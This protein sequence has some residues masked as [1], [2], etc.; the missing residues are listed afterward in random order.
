MTAFAVVEQHEREQR[1][2]LRFTGILRGFFYEPKPPVA[3]SLEA[4]E[5]GDETPNPR[6]V[7]AQLRLRLG[8]RSNSGIRLSASVGSG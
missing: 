3:V 7:R 5:I 6:I 2:P 8:M 4:R 1:T